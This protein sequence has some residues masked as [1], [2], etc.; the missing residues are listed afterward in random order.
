VTFTRS[1]YDDNN[2]NNVDNETDGRPGSSGMVVDTVVRYYDWG[3]F[4]VRED[5]V[6]VRKNGIVTF[7]CSFRR[8]VV[9][10]LLITHL[11]SVC[12]QRHGRT[13]CHG[14]HRPVFCHCGMSGRFDGP[15]GHGPSLIYLAD[16]NN[17][18]PTRHHYG[19]VDRPYPPSR[20]GGVF[21]VNVRYFS[22]IVP[23][24][25]VEVGRS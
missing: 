2:N 25:M 18:A 19:V 16:N 10:T 7:R 11:L 20:R 12:D 22:L 24:A 9:S 5:G 1:Y 13:S 15:I 4:C 21:A 3:L 17:N 14:H 8:V 23:V 6:K